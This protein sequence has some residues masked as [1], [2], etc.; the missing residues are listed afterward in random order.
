MKPQD[1]DFPWPQTTPAVTV[2][3]GL[4]M[5]LQ[6]MN[7]MPPWPT[8]HGAVKRQSSQ[9]PARRLLSIPG[10]DPTQDSR[11]LVDNI[12]E[13]H[14]NRQIIDCHCRVQRVLREKGK[15]KSSIAKLKLG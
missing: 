10:A 15:K 2:T 13:I 4:K 9:L 8:G 12:Q 5:G 1:F 14:D 3:A 11:F 7:F 6:H